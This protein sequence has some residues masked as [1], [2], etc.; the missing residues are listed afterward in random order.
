MKRSNKDTLKLSLDTIESMRKKIK[1]YYFGGKYDKERYDIYSK[2]TNL[3]L[4]SYFM[5][6]ANSK[7]HFIYSIL[8][9]L[10]GN[11]YKLNE[12]IKGFYYEV[13]TS[14]IFLDNEDFD[15]FESKANI[16]IQI[17]LDKEVVC[18]VCHTREKYNG[19]GFVINTETLVDPPI[20]RIGVW[21][22]S[23]ECLER[24]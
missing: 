14:A 11:H 20:S 13:N 5:L 16:L 19:Q 10:R 17:Y 2:F 18:P 15:K 23:Q 21:I 6:S 4:M 1:E 22:C 12:H 8:S 9:A 24:L 3:L 7:V